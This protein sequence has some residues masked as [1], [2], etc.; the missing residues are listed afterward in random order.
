MGRHAGSH[1]AA[2]PSLFSSSLSPSLPSDVLAFIAA[3][4]SGSGA[5]ASSSAPAPAAAA[6]SSAS[7]PARRRGRG[8][9]YTDIP[10]SGMRK[11]IAQ[12]LTESKVGRGERE[13]RWRSP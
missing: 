8:D 11:V 9:A 12:R 4:A 6:A 3:S 2:S 5:A 13:R 7:A 10:L 1:A